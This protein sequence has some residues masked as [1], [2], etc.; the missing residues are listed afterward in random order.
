M[1]TPDALRYLPQMGLDRRQVNQ[2]VERILVAEANGTVIVE[3]S[4]AAKVIGRANSKRRRR[5][6]RSSSSHDWQAM[7]HQLSHDCD[8]DFERARSFAAS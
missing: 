1:T 4:R 8:D 7:S 5:C 6:G 2:L 3:T